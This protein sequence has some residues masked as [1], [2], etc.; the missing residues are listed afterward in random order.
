MGLAADTN[1]VTRLHLHYSRHPIMFGFMM[2][3][4]CKPVM[5]VNSLIFAIVMSVYIVVAVKWFEE[6]DML[7]FF[8]VE[9]K[10][11]MKTTPAFCPFRFSSGSK[12]QK[13]D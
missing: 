13:A 3:F 4:M 11:Y 7:H 6:P 9:Y 8:P 10:E 2:T 1:F 12:T 5:T